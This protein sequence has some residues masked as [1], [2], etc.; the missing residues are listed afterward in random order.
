MRKILFNKWNVSTFLFICTLVAVYLLASRIA[1]FKQYN[2][3]SESDYYLLNS[4]NQ[5][6]QT[7][8]FVI[9]DSDL[10]ENTFINPIYLVNERTS[11]YLRI[12]VTVSKQKG[13]EVYSLNSY[14]DTTLPYTLTYSSDWSNGRVI[15]E[16]YNYDGEMEGE[17]G[18]CWR[19]YNKSVNNSKVEIFNCIEFQNGIEEDFE[20]VVTISIDIIEKT[21]FNGLTMWMDKPT[22]W[23]SQVV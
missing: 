16:D 22:N 21:S 2:I 10:T 14:N 18:Y 11:S 20:Y 5:R 15:T 1:F 9:R 3:F 23:Q 8:T 4:Q 7:S 17:L 13:N 19:Y 12:F 6:L